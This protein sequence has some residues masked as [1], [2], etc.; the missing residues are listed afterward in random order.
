MNESLP[1][2]SLRTIVEPPSGTRAIVMLGLGI[3][4]RGVQAVPSLCCGTCGTVVAEGLRLDQFPTQKTL[5]PDQ[6]AALLK[7]AERSYAFFTELDV[8]D[9]DMALVTESLPLVVQHFGCKG[10][11]ELVK[12]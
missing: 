7:N 9:S 5:K 8:M 1:R 10:Y 2:I 6:K 11:S 4:F 12:G 3:R